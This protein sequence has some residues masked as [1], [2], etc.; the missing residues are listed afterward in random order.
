MEYISSIDMRVYDMNAIA[1]GV[2]DLQ[3]MEVAGKGV[4]DVVDKVLGGVE[5]KEVI[6][7]SLIHI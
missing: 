1:L 7:L 3:L 4:A 6:V 5:G 2:S